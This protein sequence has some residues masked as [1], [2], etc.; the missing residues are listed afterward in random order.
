MKERKREHRKDRK[1]RK[2]SEGRISSGKQRD[3]PFVCLKKKERKGAIGHRA[4]KK[5]VRES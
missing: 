5:M 1:L 2:S 4:K 3:E